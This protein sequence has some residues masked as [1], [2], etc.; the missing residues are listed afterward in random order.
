[1]EDLPE[2]YRSKN[3]YGYEAPQISL[4]AAMMAELHDPVLAKH[5]EE[6]LG[7]M[8]GNARASIAMVVKPVVEFETIEI[9]CYERPQGNI[10]LDL[11]RQT[12]AGLPLSQLVQQE[13]TLKEGS[14]VR[15]KI[16]FKVHNTV[17]LGLKI[18]SAVDTKVKLVREDEVLGTFA[19]RAE[20]QE[21]QTDWA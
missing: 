15:F 14:W 9:E 5:K 12:Q 3:A 8:G 1:M 18:C 17:V 20:S 19:P 7:D 21:V 10:V 13:Y 2:Q 6:L 16:R 11:T 4:Q